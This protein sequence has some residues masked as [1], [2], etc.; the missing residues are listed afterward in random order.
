MKGVGSSANDRAA[1]AE[2]AVL[3]RFV[4]AFHHLPGT[5]LAQTLA[6]T[7]ELPGVVRVNGSTP[8]HY[9][10]QAHLLDAIVDGA[11][12]ALRS[13]DTNSAR[14]STRLGR[15]LQRTVILRNRGTVRNHYFDDMAWFALASGRLD[16]LHNDLRLRRGRWQRGYVHRTL[17]VELRSGLNSD[18]GVFW[19]RDRTFLAA[20]AAGPTALHLARTGRV[21]EARC[22]VEWMQS[23][24]LDTRGLVMDGLRTSGALEPQVYTYNQGPL[25]G[26]LLELG[27]EQDL[28]RASALVHAVDQ[29]LRVEG[30]RTLR[31]HGSGDGGLFTGIL[32][33]YLGLAV[34]DQRLSPGTRR[35]AAELV[36]C[37]AEALW[38]SRDAFGVFPARTGSQRGATRP[39]SDR[40]ELATQLQ[41]WMALETA[42]TLEADERAEF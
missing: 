1:A 26:A 19:N 12:R 2:S 42:A 22:V 40:V 11:I 34:V 10:W 13:G 41:G 32:V 29:H 28:E 3:G 6:P 25:L 36:R 17:T 14:I 39:T 4:G 37:T 35:R 23:R 5:R 8:L 38:D 16:G 9:W 33:R 31:T 18:D 24:L 7:G 15:R 21:A 30:T 27:E 20:A